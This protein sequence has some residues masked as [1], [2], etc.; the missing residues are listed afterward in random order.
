MEPHGL[1]AVISGESSATLADI[2]Q[3]FGGH[4]LRIP[5]RLDH[6]GFLRRRVNASLIERLEARDA[7]GT[8][9]AV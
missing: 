9:F 3:G 1:T 5:S 6:R 2:P 4:A 7:D 8:G